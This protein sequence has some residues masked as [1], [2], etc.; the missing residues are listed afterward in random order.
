MANQRASNINK[1]KKANE[2]DI[3]GKLHNRH[4][5]GDVITEDKQMLNKNQ[6]VPLHLSSILP[7]ESVAFRAFIH[8][9]KKK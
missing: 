2:I 6:R 8:I 5:I 1:M 3:E 4:H 7:T 9:V